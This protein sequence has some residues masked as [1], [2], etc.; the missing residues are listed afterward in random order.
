MPVRI[1]TT[2]LIIILVIVILLFGVGRIGR[3]GADLGQAI[4]SFREAV[5]GDDQE[6]HTQES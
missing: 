4:K 5:S 1:G 2:E 6:H 3:L